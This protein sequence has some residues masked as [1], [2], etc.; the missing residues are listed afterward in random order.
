MQHGVRAYN[1]NLPQSS[2]TSGPFWLK[3]KNLLSRSVSG[4]CFVVQLCQSRLSMGRNRKWVL[5]DNLS[6]AV[7]RTILRGPRPPLGSWQCGTRQNSSSTPARGTGGFNQGRAPLQQNRSRVFQ[8]PGNSGVAQPSDGCFVWKPRCRCSGRQSRG[9]TNQGSIEEGTR[10]M[11]RFTHWRKIG[12]NSE[13]VQR[14]RARIEKILADLTREQYLLHQA[15]ES[16]Q[17][18]RD[19]AIKSVPDPTPNGRPPVPRAQ[20]KRSEG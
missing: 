11:S 14:S 15:L 13:F 2:T 9:S 4:L 18:L 7:W 16:L 1:W 19:E 12:L 3:P 5:E 10:S 8:F 6:Q 20:W 17:R